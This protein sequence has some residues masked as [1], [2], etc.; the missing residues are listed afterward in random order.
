MVCPRCKSN[1]VNTQVVSEVKR[2]GCFTILF[3]LVLLCIPVIGWIALIALLRGNKS[4][5]HTKAVCQDCGNNWS[6]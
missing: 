4:K 5:I 6:V 3:Y 2:K 1:N